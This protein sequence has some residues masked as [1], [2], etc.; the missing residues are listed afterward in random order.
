MDTEAIEEAWDVCEVE[1]LERFNGHMIASAVFEPQYNGDFVFADRI[2]SDTQPLW[3]A[4]QSMEN[5]MFMS[6]PLDGYLRCS[7]YVYLNE[8]EKG[9]KIDIKTYSDR[10]KLAPGDTECSFEAFK[11]LINEFEQ[12]VCEIEFLGGLEEMEDR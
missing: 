11:Y 3:D 7:G 4:I 6:E 5:V 10:I 12:C 8:T 1:E 2:E 9:H